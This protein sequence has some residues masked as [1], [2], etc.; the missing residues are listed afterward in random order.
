M[1]SKKTYKSKLKD[2]FD[3][4]I[5]DRTYGI[6]PAPTDPQMAI[7]ILSAYL[8]GED[9]Y[10]VDPLPNDQ[11]NTIIIQ[12]ILFKYSKEYRKRFKRLRKKY[13]RERK[14]KSEM[15]NFK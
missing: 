14:K 7:H 1:N 10:I 6:F 2:D 12:D 4:I 13:K 5:A 3:K 8:L 15:R 11:A 9:Y